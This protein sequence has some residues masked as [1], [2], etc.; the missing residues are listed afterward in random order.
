MM[1]ERTSRS[2]FLAKRWGYVRLSTSL[3]RNSI[4][5]Y[6]NTLIN[7]GGGFLFTLTAT[8]YFPKQDVGYAATL[9]S[10]LA[11]VAAVSNVGMNR[12]ILRFYGDP[13]PTV[14]L[15]WSAAF[16]VVV[17][18]ALAIGLGASPILSAI[19]IPNF[20][21]IPA[22]LFSLICAVSA[23]K[24]L[25]DVYF[26]ARRKSIYTFMQNIAFVGFRLLPLVAAVAI[27]ARS[28]WIIFG[29]QMIAAGS[30][31][32]VAI[33]AF[34]R[35][36]LRFGK[37]EWRALSARSRFAVASYATDLVGGLPTSLVP[38]I[39]LA[40]LGP[41][42]AAKWF[43]LM[44]V[45][46]FIMS[47]LS[48][49]GQALLAEMATDLARMIHHLRSAAL[50]MTL[51]VV[52]VAV[53]VI[54]FAPFVLHIF[55]PAYGS[56]VNLMRLMSIF[57]VVGMINFLTGSYL[58]AH[59]RMNMLLGI[60]LANGLA[61]VSL[62]LLLPASLTAMAYAWVAGE[63]VNV[64]LF[65]AGAWRHARQQQVAVVALRQREGRSA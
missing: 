54:I 5:L 17:V 40:R 50:V 51:S 16:R 23:G 49:V 37:P 32:T 53:F 43:V 57:A 13:K 25:F 7:V 22:I 8:R 58:A 63:L 42:P 9:F 3:V 65:V 34:R 14:V 33:I 64:A 56:E 2:F 26:T 35:L 24:S 45:V 59:R 41:I 39:V 10:A 62:S 12:T 31:L 20:T 44:Q 30:G 21:L 55:G 15:E 1:I 18:A 47:L 38:I 6:A 11:I 60:N 48:S 28:F 52:P 36:K 4:W 61:V 46:T 29:T 19:G 27:G